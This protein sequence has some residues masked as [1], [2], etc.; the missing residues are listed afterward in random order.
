MAGGTAAGG[1]PPWSAGSDEAAALLRAA[2]TEGR[3]YR[4]T[5]LLMDGVSMDDADE[6]STTAVMYA[7]M[8][9]HPA[10]LRLLLEAG[11][12]VNKKNW[13]E[14]TPIGNSAM[15]VAAG[16]GEADCLRLLLDAGADKE[17]A[18]VAG[19]TPLHLAAVY[20]HTACVKMLLEAGADKNAVDAEGGSAV[21]GAAAKGW[22]D[23]L[24]VLLEAGADANEL[25]AD[26]VSPLHAAAKHGKADC[27]RLL[28]EAGAEIDRLGDPTRGTA[29]MVAAAYGH[30]DCVRMLVEA[31]ADLSLSTSEGIT[32]VTFALA[33]GNVEAAGIMMRVA[34]INPATQDK[35]LRAYARAAACGSYA[36]LLAARGGGSRDAPRHACAHCGKTSAAAKAEG[37][38]LRSCSACRSAK[39]EGADVVPPRYC[40]RACQVAAWPQHKRECA[41][42][43][44]R[45]GRARSEPAP[46]RAVPRATHQGPV[47]CTSRRAS[48]CAL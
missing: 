10:C 9:G 33:S 21:L 47:H 38:K 48:A 7:A 22:A 31:G 43:T 39:N 32:A 23:C 24:R 26:G 25:D 2:A 17:A 28:L 40:S 29:L 41:G 1:P 3:T 11:A 19:E 8:H 5:Q 12:D 30:N 18:N 13:S 37:D 14:S 44:A 35:L 46:A 42:R 15:I 16:N 4:V 34:A 20:G 45:R 6:H 27:L 36:R